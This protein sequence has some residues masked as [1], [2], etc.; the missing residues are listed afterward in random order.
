MDKENTLQKEI[1]DK[2]LGK[3]R[4]IWKEMNGRE[5]PDFPE[6]STDD[7]KQLTLGTYQL[8][9]AQHYTAQHLMED[10]CFK[11]MVCEF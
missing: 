4:T 8:R 2:G 7:L 10:A 11:M 9:M 6:L 5:I 1:E 3:K